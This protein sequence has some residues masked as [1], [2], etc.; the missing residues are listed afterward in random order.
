ME[1]AYH[2]GDPDRL[3]LNATNRCTNRCSFCVR[4]GS[5]GLGGALLRGAEEP[6]FARLREAVVRHGGPGRFREIVWCGYGEPTCRLDLIVEAA[7]WL[8]S[9][10]AKIR[11]DTNG[12]ACVIHGRDVMAELGAAVD[13]VSVSL[14]APDRARYLQLCLP[15]LEQFR[16]RGGPPVTAAV[17]W[18]SVLDFISRAPAHFEEVQATV[19]GHALTPGEIDKCRSLALALGAHRFRVR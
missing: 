3:Y 15:D 2:Y 6:D 12:H 10:G 14:N 11:L 9:G 1:Y 4:A 13:R 5:D 7:A 18:D 8:R 17:V 19:V 16:G